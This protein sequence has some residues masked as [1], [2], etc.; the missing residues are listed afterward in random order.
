MSQEEKPFSVSDRRHFTAD[1]AVRAEAE[2]EPTPA[3]AGA[4]PAAAAGADA[5][6]IENAR[7][8]EPLEEEGPVTFAGFVLSLGAQAGALLSEAGEG[9]EGRRSLAAARSLIGIIEMLQEKTQ[10]RRTPDEDRI[11]EGLL[12]QL[13][14][15]YV[16]AA[17]AGGA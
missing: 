7:P 15:G 17:R 16:A 10:G 9:V 12:Y 5:D 3:T 1:G 2:A 4:E 6:A 14:M 13:R 8:D 11:L